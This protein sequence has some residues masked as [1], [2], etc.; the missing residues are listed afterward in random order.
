MPQLL[1]EQVDIPLKNS[2]AD[3]TRSKCNIAPNSDSSWSHAWA[4]T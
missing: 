3:D 4:I 2:L 1:E